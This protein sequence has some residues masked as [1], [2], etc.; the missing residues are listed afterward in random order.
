MSRGFG[1]VNFAEENA[2]KTAIERVNG[3]ILAGQMV[4]ISKF[5]PKK[6]RVSDN[7]ATTF[8]NVYVK[9]IT[10]K[11]EKELTKLFA[12]FGEVTSVFLSRD[13]KGR[14]FGCVNFKLNESAQKV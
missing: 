14:P 7:G 9:N 11:D 1:F 4:S 6:E 5:I 13:K 8:T 12:P 10:C 3:M 2:A